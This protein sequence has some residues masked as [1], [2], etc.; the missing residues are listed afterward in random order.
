MI[1]PT[2]RALVAAQL[3]A[4]YRQLMCDAFTSMEVAKMLRVSVTRVQQRH[5]DRS[6]WAVQ[7]GNESR[8]P[9]LQFVSNGQR[10]GQIRGLDQVFPVL[11][12]SLHP[13]SVA[14]FLTTPQPGLIR[15]GQLV[16]PIQWL[17]AGGDKRLAVAVAESVK[18]AG[19]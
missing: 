19:A 3:E 10:R 12:E 8:F 6:L 14:G 16:T 13:L 4:E 18:W 1:G 2:D 15:M 11:P 7:E 9:A 5:R 17:G